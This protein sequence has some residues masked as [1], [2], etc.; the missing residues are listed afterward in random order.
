MSTVPSPDVMPVDRAAWARELHLSNFI[1][2]YYEYRDL[3]SFPNCRSV[4]IIGPGQGLDVQVLRWRGYAV[5]TFDIDATFKPDHQGSVHD[6][7]RFERAQFDAVIASHV[8]EHLA[9]PYLDMALA[10]IARVSL[11]ALVYLPVAGRHA[12]LRCQPGI[13][14]IDWAIAVDFFNR[15]QRC[16]GLRARYMAGQHFW[17]VGRRGFGVQALLRRFG[18]SFEVL[19]H[20]R[21][22]D[23]LPSYN[24]VLKSRSIAGSA[25]T[26]AR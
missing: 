24:F 6:L 20:Y 18:R 14:A 19:R 21:N 12:Q 9:E 11:N 16:D 10:E 1:N 13:K 17:E 25:G 5:E 3:Q 4:L 8:L 23:W 2:S 7:S 22:R 15:L 26:A